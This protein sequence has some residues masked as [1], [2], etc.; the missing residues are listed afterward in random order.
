[1]GGVRISDANLWAVRVAFSAGQGRGC[2]RTMQIEEAVTRALSVDRLRTYELAVAALAPCH[3]PLDLYLWNANISAAFLIPL[4]LVE[5]VT[6][7]AVADALTTVHG[8]QWPWWQGFTDSLPCPA[9]GYSPRRELQRVAL[10]CNS[11]T[12]DVIPALSFVFWQKIF[13][14]RFDTRLWSRCLFSVLPGADT[15]TPWHVTRACMHDDLEQ[16]RRLRNRI[17]HHEPI[18]ARALADDLAAIQR[19][20]RLRCALTAEWLAELEAVSALLPERPT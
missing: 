11:R 13:T 6:R 14:R 15:S 20:V 10:R 7:N 3:T 5:V 12:A 16:I 1:M 9:G 4:H 19:V 8:P 2:R 18:F 17:A